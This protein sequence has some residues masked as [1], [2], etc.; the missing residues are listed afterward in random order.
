MKREKMQTVPQKTIEKWVLAMYNY[1]LS[2]NTLYPQVF[3]SKVPVHNAIKHKLATKSTID[4]LNNFFDKL[5]K[6]K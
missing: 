2:I 5:N 3:L 1:N 4:A 6:Q